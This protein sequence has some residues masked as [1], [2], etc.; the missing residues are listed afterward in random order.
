MPEYAIEVE[1]LSKWYGQVQAVKG[2]RFTVAQGAT[3]ALLGANGAGK[4]TTLAMLLGLLAPS[5][6]QIRLLGQDLLTHRYQLLP[7]MNF[8]SPYV[9]LPQRLTVDG[10]LTDRLLR[11]R[12]GANVL[13]VQVTPTANATDV[14]M[15]ARLDEVRRPDV[16]A[17]EGDEH[18]F[19]GN[20]SGAALNRRVRE[21]VHAILCM[22]ES[23]L[24]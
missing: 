17:G 9:D 16:P 3:C 11:L 4:T 1:G 7:R 14:L 23:Q 21:A 24:A 20:P 6:G 15:Q 13:A 8:S 18:L 10:A 5:A 12:P 19:L 22:P 2:I